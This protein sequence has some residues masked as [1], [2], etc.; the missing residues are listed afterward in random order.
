MQSTKLAAEEPSSLYEKMMDD[1]STGLLPG[2]ERL[3]VAK[4]AER[5]GVSTSPVREVLRQL[6]GE[7][8]VEFS[9]NRGA[10]V[11]K[12]S[13][14]TITEIFELLQLLEPYFVSW[15]AQD[16]SP[17]ELDELKKILV[18]LNKIP[19]EKRAEY[20]RVDAEFHGFMYSRHYN[21][22]AVEV[23]QKQRRALNVFSLSLSIGPGREKAIKEEHAILLDALEQH[24]STGAVDIISKHIAGSGEHM[25]RQFGRLRAE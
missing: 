1:I 8:F 6:Q 23:W 2:G 14:V 7:G 3:K 11:A 13:G 21:K 12:A 18:R 19:V 17:A 5:Y 16:V 4:L 20:A 15:F 9:P 22:R 24:D 10:S 25:S